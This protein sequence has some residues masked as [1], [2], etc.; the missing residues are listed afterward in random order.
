MATIRIAIIVL[1]VL[2]AMAQT[3]PVPFISLPLVPATVAPGSADFTLTV[4]G[5]GFSPSSTVDWNGSPRTT[6]FVSATQLTATILATDVAQPTSGAVSVLTPAPGGGRSNTTLLEVAI[7]RTIL[8]FNPSVV[9]PNPSP[10]VVGVADLNGDGNL[11]LVSTDSAANA[12]TIFLGNGDG[13]FRFLA[14]YPVGSKPASAAIA[15]INGDNNPDIVV[16][17]EGSNEISVLL[18]NGDGTFQPAVSYNANPVPVS[19][20]LGDFNH[21]GKLDVAVASDGGYIASILLGNGD[22][23]FQPPVG[24]GTGPNITAVAIG[25]FNG[26][27]NLDLAVTQSSPSG[28]N[29]LLG[30]GDGRFRIDRFQIADFG[31]QS[32]VVADFNGDGKPDLAVACKELAVSSVDILL[33]NGDGTF[34]PRVA[35]PTGP[36]P[37]SVVVGDMN[38]D[39]VLDLATANYDGNSTSILLGSGDGTFQPHQ[40]YLVAGASVQSLA[41]ADLNRDGL[42]DLAVAAGIG[43]ISILLQTTVVLSP[44][45]LSFGKQM[46]GTSSMAQGI[47]LTNTASVAL[48]FSGITIAGSNPGDFSETS[49]CAGT[50]APGAS[51]TISVTFTPQATGARAATVTITDNAPNS[52]Q[53]VPLTGAGIQPAVVLSPA[54]LA[55]PT[56]LIFTASAPQTVTLTN[57]GNQALS[58]TSIT[59]TGNFSQTNTCGTSLAPGVSCTISVTFRPLSKGPLTGMLSVTDNAP[60]SPQTVS[61]AGTGTYVRLQPTSLSLGTQPVGTMSLPRKI[62]LSNKGSMPL[63]IASIT[64]AGAGAGDFAQ[65]N[66][67]GSRVA[68][69]ASCFITVTFTPTAKGRRTA[70]VSISD[71][72]GGSPQLVGLT[73]T[74]T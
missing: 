66:T 64:I 49:T 21:D 18:G 6:T 22:G 37:Y 40:E 70:D 20:A 10:S 62:T 7:P 16:A 17:D 47:T 29:I 23:T 55:Y 12:I 30:Y 8:S 72:G 67:C 26:D 46:V 69:G 56:Q 39:G 1:A 68:A 25:D 42:P 57:T 38:G 13:T 24:Y 19:I 31:A 48:D 32:V 41:V 14:D 36:K 58:V 45:S 4:N 63:G 52:P 60:G 59:T 53:T 65:T 34:S 28:V 9:T 44:R 61:L 35:F 43:P 11:D 73:G 74:G 3:N 51:C 2:P 50:V 27:G 15:D 71:N 5:A 54:T 33:G